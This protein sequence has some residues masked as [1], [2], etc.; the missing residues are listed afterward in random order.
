MARVAKGINSTYLFGKETNYGT[1][2]SPTKDIGLVQSFTV[3]PTQNATERHGAG[4]SNAVCVK[5]GLVN[6]AGSVE[7]EL[8]HGRPI[9]WAIFGGTTTH[10]ATNDDIVHTF[11][12]ANNLSSY[13]VEASQE[14]EATDTSMLIDGL[15]FNDST[16]SMGVDGIITM[17]SGW[18]ARDINTSSTTASAAVVNTGCPLG[19]YEAGLSLGGGNVDYVQSWELNVNRNSKNI[20]GAGS[21]KPADGGSHITNVSFRATI[22]FENTTQMNRLLGGTSISDTTADNFP[23]VLSADNGV[24]LG[25]GKRALSLTLSSAQLND[26]SINSTINDFIMYDISGVGILSAGS[27]TDQVTEAS[28]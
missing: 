22:G 14:K 8:Q 26:W 5:G 10:E 11:V 9:E 16:I 2:V 15:Y 23:V 21:R 20:H 7:L 24:A 28:W 6:P 12:W 27:K 4:Q 19:G 13:T 18:I 17:R 1:P 3:N 25:S